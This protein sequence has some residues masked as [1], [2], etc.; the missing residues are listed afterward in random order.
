MCVSAEAGKGPKARKAWKTDS[1]ASTAI[2]PRLLLQ[3]LPPSVW[4]NLE[5]SGELLQ[6]MAS[7]D[8]CAHQHS[9]FSHAAGRLTSCHKAV[10]PAQRNWC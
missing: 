7:I 9:C 5:G 4:S 1:A 8:T 3:S 10:C 6:A 2:S